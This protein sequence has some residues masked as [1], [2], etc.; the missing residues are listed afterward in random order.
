MPVLKTGAATF[1]SGSSSF[2]LK[3]LSGPRSRPTATQKMWQPRESNPGPQGLQPGTLT[4]KPL[5]VE[6]KN[7]ISGLLLVHN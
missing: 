1:H 4:A 5:R 2:I 7:N 3:M 6:D